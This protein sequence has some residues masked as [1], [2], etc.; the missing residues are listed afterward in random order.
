MKTKREIE[1]T[2]EK[3]QKLRFIEEQNLSEALSVMLLRRINHPTVKTMSPDKF[4]RRAEPS[5]TIKKYL[6]RY[7]KYLSSCVD[8]ELYIIMLIYIDSYLKHS[9]KNLNRL[10]IHSLISA[11][12][13]LACK[14]HLDGFYDNAFYA[15]IA[16]LS[17]SEMNSLE[18]EFF[19]KELG[20]RHLHIE[21]NTFDEYA[22]AVDVAERESFKYHLR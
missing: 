18:A 12:L 8:K 7:M 20:G 16:G 15:K 1:E 22:A 5:I 17:L 19:L 2:P 10:N 4:F 6:L 21:K 14:F 11:S 3:H 13:L 9:S